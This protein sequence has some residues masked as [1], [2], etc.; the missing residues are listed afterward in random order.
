MDIN[1]SIDDPKE[2]MFCHECSICSIP[3]SV[4]EDKVENKS[5]KKREINQE[6]LDDLT[7]ACIQELMSSSTTELEKDVYMSDDY[8]TFRF[9]DPTKNLGAGW[10]KIGTIKPPKKEV[11][12]V[13]L[14]KIAPRYL[15]EVND[16]NNS[17]M[18]GGRSYDWEPMLGIGS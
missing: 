18:I 1:I 10:K 2:F 11:D 5:K 9:S 16:G 6:F 7:I 12:G 14:I 17:I 8:A 13:E 15:Y 3:K 4:V